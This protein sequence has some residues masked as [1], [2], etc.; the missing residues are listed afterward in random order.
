M[1]TEGVSSGATPQMK[2]T[3]WSPSIKTPF[4]L[5]TNGCVDVVVGVGVCAAPSRRSDTN[6]NRKMALSSIDRSESRATAVAN[7]FSGWLEL[8]DC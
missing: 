8:E 1:L 2:Y 4:T 7:E 5:L 3:C 6:T